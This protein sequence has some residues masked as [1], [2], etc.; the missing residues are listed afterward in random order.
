MDNYSGSKQGDLISTIKL[1][2]FNDL[3]NIL[4]GVCEF[5]KPADGCQV[6]N[7]QNFGVICNPLTPL[8]NHKIVKTKILIHPSWTDSKQSVNEIRSVGKATHSTED[9]EEEKYKLEVL[10]EAKISINQSATP[11]SVILSGNETSLSRS[12]TENKCSSPSKS[13]KRKPISFPNQ[14]PSEDQN[15]LS[16]RWDVVYKTILRDFR[17]YFQSLFKERVNFSYR[18]KSRMFRQQLEEFWNTL[19]SSHFDQATN[20]QSVV[21]HVGSLIC[22]NDMIKYKIH[23]VDSNGVPLS[24]KYKDTKLQ[25]IKRVHDWLYK[26]SIQKAMELMKNKYYIKL[27][28]VYYNSIINGSVEMTD[29]MNK[30]RQAYLKAFKMLLGETH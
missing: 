12:E 13:L 7:E 18:K 27:F 10:G 21:F 22:P 24:G 2:S 23:L 16:S 11:K 14:R 26:F 8:K 25:D 15:F 20:F 6:Q 5:S 17:R 3:E 9:L 30:N 29:T 4:K 1:P 19:M 28:R